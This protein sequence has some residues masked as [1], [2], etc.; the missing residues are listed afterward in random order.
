V[1]EPARVAAV[2]SV[3]KVTL[4]ED[5]AEVTRRA[6]AALPAGTSWVA[7][8]GVTALVD[9]TS[10]ATTIAGERARVVATRI[11][12]QV[13]EER[14]AGD[15]E[16][17]R[18]E[19]D[20]RAAV[21]R[22]IEAERAVVRAAS[23][24]SRADA[25]AERW[26]ESTAR[27]GG[28]DGTQALGDAWGAIDGALVNALDASSAARSELEKAQHDER[29]ASLRLVQAR[30]ITPRFDAVVEVQVIARD[31]HECEI[32]LSY[33][34]PCALW[35]PEHV[36]RLD[37]DSLTIA[38]MATVWQRTGEEWRG[39]SCRFS[40]ARPTHAASAPLLADD[41]VAMRKKSDQE[42][43]TVA[44]EARDQ[45]VALAGLDRG[46]RAVEE[47]PGVEDG[48]EPL[49]F[50][51]QA[52]VT[53][54][55][56][57]QPVRVAIGE[58]SLRAAVE[59]VA[60]PERAEAAHLRATATLTGGTP[61]LAAPVRLVRGR[62]LVGRGRVGF[63]AAGDPFELGFGPDDG[64]RVRRRVDER[65]ETAALTGTQRIDR[66]VHLFFSNLGGDAKKLLTCE[67]IPVSEIGDVTIKI[68]QPI[69]GASFDERDGFLRFTVELAPR[70]T[71]EIVF[72]WRIEAAAKVQLPF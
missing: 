7:I 62:S 43:R 2:S 55:S 10:L 6:K 49:T 70:A 19:A 65:R 40:T 20:E 4:F 31:A 27:A 36:A 28:S 66:T 21:R 24:E 3:E 15:E 45:T 44:V 53:L 23:A 26:L 34:T 64:V 59:L 8:G 14:A 67:R 16:V 35:R 63:V 68:T 71:R 18:A 29:R 41:V 38:T 12:R 69:P 58:R 51:A 50:D 42:R 52:P 57:G 25:L 13:R 48:G 32:E 37:G 9:D 30:T 60:F 47:M 22:R 61:L 72:A 46:V 5:R 39:V 17:S 1:S 56:D 11:V 33:R 54:P